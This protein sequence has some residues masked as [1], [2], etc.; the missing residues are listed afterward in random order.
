MSS[1]P[2]LRSR[3]MASVIAAMALAFMGA[4][5]HA[6]EESGKVVKT[7]HKSVK[8]V[9]TRTKAPKARIRRAVA[10]VPSVPSF[11]QLAGLHRAED[12]LSLLAS[13][14]YV[15][16]QQAGDVLL[17]K[18]ADAVLPIASITKLMT[19]LVVLD[20]KQPLDELIEITE[21]DVDTEKHSRSRLAVGT[22]LS[23][24]DMLHLA[25]MSSE[26]RAAHALGRNYPGGTAAFV[27]AMNA[28]AQMLGMHSS[29][30]VEPTGLS[31]KNVASAG[32][33][34]RLVRAGYEQ[35]LIREYTTATDY[36]VRIGHRIQRFRNTNQLVSN[37]DWEIGLSKTGFITEAGKCL[38]MQAKI[39]GKAVVIV[40]LDSIGRLG[41]VGDAKRIRNWLETVASRKIS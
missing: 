6:A 8:R 7:A 34:A 2:S 23:R 13:V 32:D 20:A 28:K 17:A 19:A 4:P 3:L 26:N 41:R 39:Q 15:Q 37:P 38:V 18:N 14:A 5:L 29:Q 9:A 25:L 10:V 30:F 27:E 36:D 22:Q 21:D 40:I 12:P 33:L 11:G 16:D 31:S 35:P 24:A 1:K